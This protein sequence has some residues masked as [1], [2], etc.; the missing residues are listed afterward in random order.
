MIEHQEHFGRKFYQ[1][2]KK[3]YWISTDYPRIRAHRWIWI[4][5]HGQ[6]PKGYHIHHKNEDKSDNNIENLELIE[7]SRHLKLHIT[8]EKREWARKWAAIIRPLTKEWHSSEE[9]LVWHKLH[10]MRC[11]KNKKEITITCD[12]CGNKAQTKMYHQRF[13]SNKCKSKFRRD[14]RLDDITRIC[15]SCGKEFVVNKYKK[16]K[17]CSRQC[18]QRGRK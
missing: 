7:R 14:N 10:G 16:T 1:D 6:I 3:G 12:V 4:N 5:V 8:E 13:C 15:Q 17:N 2:K 9:G 11:W 18:A